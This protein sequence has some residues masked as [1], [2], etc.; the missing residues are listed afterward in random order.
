M[1][2]VGAVG[3]VFAAIGIPIVLLGWAATDRFMRR[4]HDQHPDLWQ[5]LG[6]PWGIFWVPP[7]ADHSIAAAFRTTNA[8]NRIL[9]QLALF[10]TPRPLEVRRAEL[11]ADLQRLESLTRWSGFLAV[12][13]LVFVAAN[14]AA[15]AASA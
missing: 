8:R 10:K 14:V 1:A 7:E 3:L 9:L 13:W 2:L 4:L 5:E 15:L 12:A 6:S 11:G